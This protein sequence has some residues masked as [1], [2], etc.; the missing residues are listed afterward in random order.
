MTDIPALHI[1]FDAADPDRVAR[2]WLT[3]LT[4]YDWPAPPPDGYATW[5]AWGDAQGIPA[6]QRNRSRTI[7]DKS[8]G[9]R[10][11]I[12][13]LQ[14]P[15]AKAGK[16]RLHLDIKI[17]AGAPAGERGALLDAE[18][19]RLCAAGAALLHT[20]DEAEGYWHVLQD[21]EGNE[22]CVI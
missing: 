8:G 7:V 6:E 18:A 11:D 15:E 12:F 4:G 13:F 3:A 22:F 2:F 14:V 10:P 1:V 21:P 17:A 9:N 19:E 20:V 16:N 5:D